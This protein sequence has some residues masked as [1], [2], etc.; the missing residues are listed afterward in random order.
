M[1]DKTRDIV[2]STKH[3]AELVDHPIADIDADLAFQEV[4]RAARSYSMVSKE[5]L[6]SLF[7]A[8]RY[9]ARR[10]IPGDIVE[11]GVW[12]GGSSL[13]AGLT[14]KAVARPSAKRRLFDVLKP[15]SA[16]RKVWLYDTFEGMTAPTDRDVEIGGRTA[17]SYL[18]QYADSGRWCYSAEDEVRENLLSGGLSPADF[19]MIKGD[20]LQTLRNRRPGRISVLRLDTDWYESTKFELEVLYPLLS[21]GGVLIVDDYGHWSGA[22]QAVDE[23]FASSHPQLFLQ[24]TTYTVRT[25]I[26][27]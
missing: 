5:A 26:K 3:R 18:E 9:V 16:R 11:C 20:V 7:E 21:P 25:A 22:R 4:F 23:Y 12:R 17:R 1:N 2:F 15:R 24:R 13:L 10:D 14:L 19:V 6:Y 8:V 27:A